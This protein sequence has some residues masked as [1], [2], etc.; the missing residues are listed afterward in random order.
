MQ[1]AAEVQKAA[2]L[3]AQQTADAGVDS[4]NINAL[5]DPLNTSLFS[6]S[7]S[8]SQVLSSQSTSPSTWSASSDDKPEEVRP[9][10]GKRK[11]IGMVTQVHII[12]LLIIVLLVN[13]DMPSEPSTDSQPIRQQKK[14]CMYVAFIVYNLQ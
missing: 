13:L 12:W 8:S 5:A 7:H 14:K 11:A 9:P 1:R 3:K 10:R 4:T 2:E 6:L